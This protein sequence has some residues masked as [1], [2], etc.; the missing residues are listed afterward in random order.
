M[1]ILHVV[2]TTI[3]GSITSFLEWSNDTFFI[4]NSR[5]VTYYCIYCTLVAG[6]LKVFL[7]GS[8]VLNR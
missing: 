3:R 2:A 6:S 5:V 4:F 8:G 7:E 1:N